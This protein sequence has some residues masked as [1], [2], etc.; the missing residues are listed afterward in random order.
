MRNI[1]LIILIAF[2][3]PL[4]SFDNAS[5]KDLFP[6]KL[7][8]TVRDNL[9]N[10]VQGATVTLYNNETDYRNNENQAYATMT[11]DEKGKVKFKGIDPKAYFVEAKK[12]DMSNAG[13]G[14]QTQHLEKGK[15][16]RVTIIIM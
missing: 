9:G 2:A 12:G 3:T 10:P 13:G 5:T 4:F 16:N 14:I 15:N 8:I 6:T 11:T 7:N 1:V